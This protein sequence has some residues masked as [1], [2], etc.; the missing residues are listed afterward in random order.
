MPEPDLEFTDL[1]HKYSLRGVEI[2]SCTRVLTAVGAA[3]SFWF[4]TEQELKYYQDRGSA[5]HKTIELLIKGKLDKRGPK[6]LK[7]YIAGWERFANDYNVEV[8][9]FD[10]ESTVG[11]LCGPFVERP[12][13]HEIY[14]YGVTPDVV[15]KVNGIVSVIEIKATS[16]HS[17]ATA[18]QCSAQAMAVGQ[19]L[20]CENIDRWAVRLLPDEPYF[21]PKHFTE[22]G[23]RSTWIGMLSTYNWL[24]RHNMIKPGERR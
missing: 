19:A 21:E 15:A 7:P 4:L 2:P 14:R 22:R 5:V 23:D 16:S 6:W 8:I 3:P 1:D 10:H 24:T 17:P 11:M 12:L 9:D 13:H 20:D 18:I